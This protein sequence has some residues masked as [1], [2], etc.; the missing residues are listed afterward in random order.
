MV[1]LPEGGKGRPRVSNENLW[2]AEWERAFHAGSN[3][4]E[5]APGGSFSLLGGK[6]CR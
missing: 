1:G 6:D 3:L 4:F 5:G 2:G